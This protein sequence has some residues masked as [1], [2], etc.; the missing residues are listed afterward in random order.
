VA[1][2]FCA[3][4]PLPGR[5]ICIPITAYDNARLDPETRRVAGIAFEITCA[6]LKLTA[7]DQSMKSLIAGKIIELVRAGEVDP[8]R[9]CERTLIELRRG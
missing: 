4:P 1:E 9:L 3:L 7:R 8:E 6:A 2:R 5:R